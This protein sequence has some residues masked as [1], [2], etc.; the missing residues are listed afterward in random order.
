MKRKQ[1]MIYEYSL[2][3]PVYNE[4]ARLISGVK[5][6]LE[7]LKKE[8]RSWELILVDDGSSLAVETVIQESS[9]L[10]KL[11]KK[12]VKEKKIRILRLPQN[13]GKGKAIAEGVKSAKGNVVFFMD[14]DCS[15]S[16]TVIPVFLAALVKND[17]AIASRRLPESVLVVRQGKL[18]EFGGRVYTALANLVCRIDVLDATCGFKGFKKS[19]ARKLFSFSRVHRWSFDTE[20]L[21]LARK[22]RYAII[23]VPVSW[24]NKRGSRVKLS[25]TGRS[26]LD[27]L[28]IRINDSQGLY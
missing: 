4:V 11:V 7:Y 6:I 2:V 27:L 17:V 24:T 12:F 3:V 19:T 25:D 23:Q 10:S 18:R 9:E 13:K 28:T 22:Y 15:V 20:I 16:P 14:V 1:I 5:E 21:Y 26:F 8:K